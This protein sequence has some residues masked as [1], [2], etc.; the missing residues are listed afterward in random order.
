[1]MKH[2]LLGDRDARGGMSIGKHSI[3]MSPTLSTARRMRKTARLSL[4][5][6]AR[7]LEEVSESTNHPSEK[8]VY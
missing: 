2:I 7:D 3:E 1:M 6:G 4:R 5:R 8:S